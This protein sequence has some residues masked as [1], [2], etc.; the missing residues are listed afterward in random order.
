MQVEETGTGT[1]E[2]LGNVV[3]QGWCYGFFVLYQLD[4][5]G[6]AFILWQAIHQ[7]LESNTDQHGAGHRN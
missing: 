7:R 6:S 5:V 3:I 1:W 4:K 2:V